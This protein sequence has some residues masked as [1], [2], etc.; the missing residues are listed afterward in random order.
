[1]MFPVL[2]MLSKELDFML[3]QCDYGNGGRQYGV[4]PG[5]HTAMTS[6][7]IPEWVGVW[8]EILFKER[9]RDVKHDKPDTK[10][11][12][13]RKGVLQKSSM[14]ADVDT[15][16]GIMVTPKIRFDVLRMSTKPT[17][18]ESSAATI[19]NT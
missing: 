7:H 11:L 9:W 3:Q 17:K 8:K 4:T 12:A 19:T 2:R 6:V 1:M 15:L 18:F 10:P 14:I 13:K 5:S 16:T